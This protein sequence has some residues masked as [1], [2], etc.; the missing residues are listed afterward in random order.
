MSNRRIER[1]V[2]LEY[3]EELFKQSSFLFFA[4]YKGLTVKKLTNLRNRLHGNGSGCVVLKNSYIILGLKKMGVTVPD[5]FS[6]SGDT[7]VIL[8]SGD[9]CATAKIIKEFSKENDQVAAKGGVVDGKLLNPAGVAAL[10]DLPP[11]EV[12]LSQLLF[13][14]KSPA[15]RL[16]RVLSA[17]KNSI[18][19]TLENYAKKLEEKKS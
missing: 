9:V 3:V 5:S 11:K 7:M 14:M 1:T 12:L 2:L 18:V 8:G 13:M 15:Q 4:S 17:R 16:V 19:W 10:A 6:L